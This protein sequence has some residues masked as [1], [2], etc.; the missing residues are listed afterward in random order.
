MLLLILFLFFTTS[1]FAA[2]EF[3]INQSID[4]TLEQNNKTSVSH[5]VEITN[6]FS[7]I[8]PQK[9]QIQISNYQIEN[10]KASDDGGSIIEKIEK[11]STSTTIHFKFNQQNTGKN[12]ITSFKIN[13]QILNLLKNKGSV[14]E[15]ELPF[16]SDSCTNCRQNISL[17]VPSSFGNPSF[18][19]IPI[20]NLESN[21]D[22]LIIHYNLNKEKNKKLFLIFGNYQIFDFSLKYFLENNT[23]FPAIYQIAIPPDLNNQQ[24][25]YKQ[26][27]PFFQNI[28]VDADGNWLAQYLID[29]NQKLEVNIEGQTK[30]S[31]PKSTEEISDQ[32]LYTQEQKFWPTSNPKIQT[33]VKTLKTPKQIYDFVVN[34]LNY[35]YASINSAYRKGALA[36]LD[37]PNSC[38]CTEF[39][40]LFVTLARAKN[41]PAREIEGFAYT[42]NSRLKPINVN[43]D[44]L[45][46]WP[47]FYDSQKKQWL[48]VDPTWTKTTN[49]ID[50]F[51]DLDLNHFAFVIHGQ[52]SELPLPPGSYKNDQNTKTVSV[53]L[54]K[55]ELSKNITRPTLTLNSKDNSITI[56]NPNFFSLKDIN[57]TLTNNGYHTLINLL[58][59]LSS[60]TIHP[61]N[62]NFFQ[63]LIPKN[64]HLAFALKHQDIQQEEKYILVN[65]KHYFNLAI[66]II[67]LTIILSFGG[68]ILTIPKIRHEKNT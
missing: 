35:D 9:Y 43:T 11:N 68:I 44:I 48:S 27:D 39:T 28:T 67:S 21:N 34:T 56:Y 3:T 2:D 30:I 66:S 13:Y 65:K 33:L 16:Y 57:I 40:D 32:N 17:S 55:T 58:P 59:P 38:L 19:S 61:T 1:V 25:I 12:N 49:G 24:I 63:S 10:I 47:Q 52:N 23:S 62:L 60:S 22:K 26:I 45:H 15:I 18:T 8:Y 7:Q 46:A 42:T 36:A 37:T 31:A 53:D 64:S 29:A 54:A 50:Y 51:N 5:Q 41:I 4:Y 6:N 20:S 14:K